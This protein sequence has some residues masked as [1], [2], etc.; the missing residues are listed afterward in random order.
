MKKLSIAVAIAVVAIMT[1]CGNGTPKANLND[2]I[3]TLSYAIGM[4]Q[5]TGLRNYLVQRMGVDTL[6]LD[7]FIKGLNDAVNAGDDKK[8]TAYYAG[9]QIGQ[10]VSQQIYKGINH[11]L[12]GNDST[13]TIS[14]SNFVAGFVSGTLEKGGLM[15]QENAQQTAQRIM[16]EIK[17]EQMEKLYG[18]W[19]RE[20]E[21][22]MNRIAKQ[23]GVE[24]L[25]DGVYYEVL[26]EGTGSIPEAT[27]RV[28]VDYEGKLINDTV[29]DS[30]YKR[31]E[32]GE[33]YC[34]RVIK[35]WGEAL[36]S[37]PVGSKWKVYISAD[38]GYGEREAGDIKPFSAL[39]FTI[40]LKEIITK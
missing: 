10:Q 1:S 34:N 36:A 37:M 3:D 32:P 18:D 31:G 38:K 29:F 13:Q 5:S 26:E 21:A 23:E 12:F 8:K 14:L 27:D 6:Y 20:N 22:F 2:N 17:A 40:E 4:A 11:E 39:V 30:T 15:T 25:S 28:R 24:K 35:G 9:L 16:D 19:R 33:L 7:E